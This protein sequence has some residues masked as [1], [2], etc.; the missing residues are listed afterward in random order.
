MTNII[1]LV[2][3]DAGGA[4]LL[5]SWANK[6]K[7]KLN[8]EIFCSGPAQAIFLE[9]FKS[10]SSYNSLM[11]N[12]YINQNKD[13]IS[14]VVTTTGW[15]SD[16]E[17]EA[18]NYAKKVGLKTST[19]IDHW[20]NY[21]ERFNYK[22]KTILPYEIWIHD[23]YSKIIAN[24]TFKSIKIKMKKNEYLE[25][26]IRNN[27]QKEQNILLFVLEPIRNIST[28]QQ[29]KIYNKLISYI[30]T[31]FKHSLKFIIRQ[32]PSENNPFTSLLKNKLLNFGFQEIQS[33]K[34]LIDDLQISK[35]IFSYQSSIFDIAIKMNK[36][37]FSYCLSDSNI[38]PHTEI[39]YPLK[40]QHVT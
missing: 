5:A 11:F 21:N 36:V 9:Y 34:D 19:Y 22:N 2:S 7:E 20:L 1:V 16:V 33:N 4:R 23:H 31:S 10:T 32:H 15:S 18:L 14:R 39:L 6:R 29:E 25:D 17:K 13:S 35:Y 26:F 38:L 24:K 27:K 30:D 37:C 8:F 12:K 28:E 40:A 3:H